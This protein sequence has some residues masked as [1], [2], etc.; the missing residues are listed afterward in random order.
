MRVYIVT[1][2]DNVQLL[3]PC[4]DESYYEIRKVGYGNPY[5]GTWK[6]VRVKRLI[7]PRN[8]KLEEL[9][10]FS[11]IAAKANIPA[12]SDNAKELLFCHL[13]NGAQWLDLEFPEKRYSLLNIVKLSDSLDLDRSV[14]EYFSHGPIRAVDT[15]AFYETRL[16]NELLFKIRQYP[17]D[18]LA[19]DDF[20]SFAE[21]HDLTGLYFQ[22]VW[23]SNHEPFRAAPDKRY[24]QTRPDVFGPEGFVTNYRECWPEEWVQEAAR[25]KVK[26]S[27]KEK[28]SVG[29]TK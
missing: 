10:D 23:D 20:R 27:S 14:I 24:V 21:Q 26:M 3:E 22:P 18:V 2:H 1:T 12:L 9:C 8:R 29:K 11:T 17:Y 13:S 6:S 4:E 16:K 19:T 5:P 15:F 25:L 28:S 7:K